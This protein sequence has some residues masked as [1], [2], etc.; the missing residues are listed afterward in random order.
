M[1]RLKKIA[2]LSLGGAITLGM[3]LAITALILVQTQWFRDRIRERIVYELENATGGRVELGG[4][5]FDWRKRTAE[6]RNL[7]IHG[8]EG[9]GQAPLLRTDSVK[10]GLKIVSVFRRQIELESLVVNKPRVNLIIYEDGRTNMP[11][12][13]AVRERREDTVQAVLDLAIGHFN[14]VD[15]ALQ[16]GMRK[17]PFEA[18]GEHFRAQVLYEAVGPRYRGQVSFRQSISGAG[19]KPLPPLEVEARLALERK[20]LEITE[21]RLAMKGSSLEAK[22]AIEDFASPRTELQYRA[23]I[24]LKDLGAALPRGALLDRGTVKLEGKVTVPGGGQYAVSGRLEGQGLA[25]ERGGVRISD[26]GV[27]SELAL[28]PEKLEFRNFTIRA[29]HGRVSGR[30]ELL[31]FK[32]LRVAAE[33]QDFS[34]QELTRVEGAR[35]VAWDGMLSG[36]MVV[37]GEIREGDVREVNARAELTISPAPGGNPLEGLIDASYSQR[38]G[39]IELGHSYLATPSSRVQFNGTLGRRLEVRVESTD[40]GDFE[41]A[42]ALL[43][44]APAQPLP[45]RLDNGRARFEGVVSGPLEAPQIEGRVQATR[46]VFENRLFDD[47][48][49]HVAASEGNLRVEKLAVEKQQM[50][51]SG[52][53]EVKLRNWKPEADQPISGSLSLRAPELGQLLAEA[54]EKL[55][56]SGELRAEVKLAGTVGAP[57]ASGRITVEKGMAYGQ[58][59]ERLEAEARYVEGL[60]EAP[61]ATAHIGPS[62]IRGTAAFQHSKEDWSKGSLRFEVSSAGVPLARLKAAQDLSPGLEGKLEGEL[63]GQVSVAKAALRVTWLSGRLA[64]SNFAVEQK[65]MGNLALTATTKG[66]V[67][68]LD[69]SG[70]VA[71]SAIRGASQCSLEA[72]YPV[73]GNVEFARL[74]LA[75]LLARL[76]RQKGRQQ[77]P[78][79]GSAAGRLVFS[80][81][82]LQPQSWKGTL[83]LSGVEIMPRLENNKEA[84]SA[85]VLS[86][87]NRG[88]VRV[89]VDPKGARIQR[90]RFAGKHTNLQASGTVTFGSRNPWNLRLQGEVS[91]AMLQDLDPELSASGKLVVDAALRGPMSQPEVYGRAEIQGGTLYLANFPNGLDKINAVAFLYRDRATIESFTA[92]SGGGKARVTGFIVLGTP[93]TYYLQGQAEQVRYRDPEGASVTANAALNLTGTTERSVLGGDV[94]IT[95]ISF[96][97]RTDLGSLLARGAQPISTPARAGKFTQ[98]IRLDVQVRTSPQVRLETVL[99]RGLQA[100]ADLRLRGDPT[101]PVVLGRVLINQG[102]VLFFGNKYAIDSGEIL[103]VNP[104]RIE[105][106][107]NLDLQTKVQGIDVTLSLNGPIN[108]LNVTYRSDP[109]LQLSDIV[110]L[111]A[112]GTAPSSVPGLV[113]ARSAVSQS[114]EQAGAGALMSQAIA[115]PLAGR[116]QRFFGV[117]S[118]KIDP[119]LSGTTNT[120]EARLTLEQQVTNELAFT[121]VTNLTKAQEQTIRVEWGLTKHWSVVGLREENG[122][123]GIDFLYK[124]RFK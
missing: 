57:Q 122:L 93:A 5:D 87:R 68:N 24:H 71:G 124:K 61:T 112:T 80:G 119:S 73:Q 19:G 54:G 118:L 42:I 106:I 47:A 2:L 48:A 110:R 65:P 16:V 62:Q 86:L 25:L 69:L 101:R 78:F 114:W 81:S 123:F 51:L 56:V 97:P 7:V 84:A 103:F 17:L 82:M 109:P 1:R 32:D 8:T 35:R 11:I 28:G 111:L 23:H 75:T 104:A 55:P 95:R 90:A 79:D 99:T 14:L 13:K 50:R 22:G 94:T 3:A 53:F 59:F 46:A 83:E 121:Y 29:L 107:V 64:L 113:G 10:V 60:L 105:P 89:E 20:R 116:L 36:P 72:E 43:G 108:K 31:K 70:D 117:S 6:A 40:L 88:P 38:K 30:A 102:E 9:V 91:L 4:F 63:A 77:L 41:P 18:L 100:E 27:T 34:I 12:P 76:E 67:L 120:P 92:E 74:S 21:L 15:G 52:G 33:V 66:Q 26:I 44:G 85:A 58:P 96:N 39:S 115:T 45:V 37:G 98:G 49:A